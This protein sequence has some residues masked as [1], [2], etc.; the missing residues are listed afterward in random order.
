VLQQR[1]LATIVPVRQACIS[2]PIQVRLAPAP[3][4]PTAAS[5]FLSQVPRTLGRFIRF[6]DASPGSLADI[7]PGQFNRPGRNA[8]HRI[9]PGTKALLAVGNS[10]F[11]V[12]SKVRHPTRYPWSS[13]DSGSATFYNTAGTIVLYQTLAL[14]IVKTSMNVSFFILAGQATS[15]TTSPFAQVGIACAAPLAG[16]TA[17]CSAAD[18]LTV[19]ST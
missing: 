4:R 13:R 11:L 7:A 14:T 9:S 6:V 12:A 17:T 5:E 16:G 18:T 15:P 1:R 19:S 2:P 3:S 8:G 10:V